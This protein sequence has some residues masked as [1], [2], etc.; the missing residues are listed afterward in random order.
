MKIPTVF[1]LFTWGL[2][3]RGRDYNLVTR[4]GNFH[5]NGSEHLAEG[6]LNREYHLFLLT[7]ILGTVVYVCVS[8]C[9]MCMHMCCNG[10]QGGSPPSGSNYSLALLERRAG[11]R[12]RR[13][14]LQGPIRKAGCVS[15]DTWW[16]WCPSMLLGM[17][18]GSGWLGPNPKPDTAGG[19][20]AEERKEGEEQERKRG[21]MWFLSLGGSL[22]SPHPTA[23]LSYTRAYRC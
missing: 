22:S 19:E 10:N 18:A 20:T 8:L 7:A 3:E 6:M 16:L 1:M 2:L 12:R 15:M 23:M 13:G 5:I 17:T 21:R 11:R 9:S 4:D 14:C